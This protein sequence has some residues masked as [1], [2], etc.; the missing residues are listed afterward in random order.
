[1]IGTVSTP[2]NA[3]NANNERNVNIDGS[4]TNNTA[5]NGNNG[6]RPDWKKQLGPTK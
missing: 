5:Y 2:P 6:V 1:M 4:L 3:S